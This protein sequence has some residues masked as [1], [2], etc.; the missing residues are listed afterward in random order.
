MY[1]THKTLVGLKEKVDT[2]S[3][4]LKRVVPLTRITLRNNE[5]NK[6]LNM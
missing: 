5:I 3:F 2:K 6:K 4:L 1:S